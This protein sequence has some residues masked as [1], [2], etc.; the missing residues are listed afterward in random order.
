MFVK[1][2]V[3]ILVNRGGCLTI[4]HCPSFLQQYLSYFVDTEAI[5]LRFFV[6]F[7]HVI[8]ITAQNILSNNSTC[9]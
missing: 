2:V 5:S 8:N 1:T 9:V 3:K 6:D 4:F 7:I